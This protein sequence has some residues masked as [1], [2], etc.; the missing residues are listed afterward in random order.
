[1]RGLQEVFQVAHG[2]DVGP[3]PFGCQAVHVHDA[4][5]TRL[6]FERVMNDQAVGMLVRRFPA[7][8]SVQFKRLGDGRGRA[9]Q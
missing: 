6:V 9:G 1:M 7:V 5:V 4:M 8:A 3:V 2:E